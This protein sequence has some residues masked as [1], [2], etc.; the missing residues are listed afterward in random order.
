MA[1]YQLTASEEPC[2]IRRTEDDAFIPPDPANR[3]YVEYLA[4]VE[5]GGVPDPYEPPAPTPE[6]LTPAQEVAFDHENRLLAIEGLPP[7]TLDDFM[8][9][10]MT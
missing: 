5:E 8:T 7:M 3:D 6:V 9:K 10:K 4:W 2:I 1:D